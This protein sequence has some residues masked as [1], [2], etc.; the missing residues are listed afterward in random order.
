MRN[1]RQ[2]QSILFAVNRHDSAFKVIF[3][4][5]AP[6]VFFIKKTC[7]IFNVPL[8]SCSNP[9]ISSISVIIYPIVSSQIVTRAR[10]F[11]TEIAG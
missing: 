7:C 5:V 4:V 2:N 1:V 9:Q 10:I 11:W 6:N 8:T 3:W